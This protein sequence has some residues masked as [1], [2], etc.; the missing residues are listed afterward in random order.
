METNQTWSG[1]EAKAPH[2]LA[3]GGLAR[4]SASLSP[5]GCMSGWRIGE[6]MCL[7]FADECMRE[8]CVCHRNNR[9]R[10]VETSVVKLPIRKEE[11]LSN[12]GEERRGHR[13]TVLPERGVRKSQRGGTVPT[14]N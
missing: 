5:T 8:N 11:R 14:C 3:G 7:L 4:A 2:W 1:G 6:G 10:G 12:D 13:G 9:S